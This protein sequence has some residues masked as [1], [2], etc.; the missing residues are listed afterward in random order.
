MLQFD[1]SDISPVKKKSK[2][3]EYIR[4]QPKKI[5]K[6]RIAEWDI[7]NNYGWLKNHRG[8]KVFIHKRQCN[9]NPNEGNLIEYEIEIS[10]SNYEGKDNR[11]GKKFRA[12]E[13]KLQTKLIHGE[14]IQFSLY[15]GWG[16]IRR[17]DGGGDIF[18]HKNHAP[19]IHEGMEV[20][21]DVTEDY[22]GIFNGTFFFFFNNIV[23]IFFIETLRQPCP[24][25]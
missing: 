5:F 12:C 11:G 23:V 6:G 20:I 19:W 3:E 21:F 10:T 15:Y 14:V 9:F 18:V 16:M 17:K 8:Q 25:T 4:V 2:H 13:V 22:R 24:S 7:E 1:R